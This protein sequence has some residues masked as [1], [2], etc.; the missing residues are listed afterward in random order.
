M[1]RQN[2]GLKAW[3]SPKAGTALM[4]HVVLPAAIDYSNQAKLPT[5]VAY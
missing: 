1:G 3:N 4:P 2:Q 5:A